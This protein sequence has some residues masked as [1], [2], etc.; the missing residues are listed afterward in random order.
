MTSSSRLEVIDRTGLTE[1]VTY[2]RNPGVMIRNGR[3]YLGWVSYGI[4]VFNGTGMNRAD[5][6]DAKDLVGRIVITPPAFEGLSIG[7]SGGA[8]EQ[9]DGDR[10]RAGAFVAFERERGRIAVEAL[11][12]TYAGV[13]REGFYVLGVWRHVPAAPAPHFRGLEIVAR[14]VQFD[15]PEAMRDATPDASFIPLR[16]REIQFGGNYLINR[17]LRLMLNAVVPLDDRDVPAAM[18]IGRFQV[19]L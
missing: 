5:E 7:I 12:E 11:R 3:P 9:A 19:L 16:T 10:E 18:L 4:G 6:N 2:E 14:F 1:A 13:R 17:G 15:D 8:G